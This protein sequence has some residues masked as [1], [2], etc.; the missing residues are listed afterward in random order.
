MDFIKT[1]RVLIFASFLMLF[2]LVAS[3]IASA[4]SEI[5]DPGYEQRVKEFEEAF[6]FINE[7]A[8]VKNKNGDVIDFDFDR[9]RELLGE[10]E[11]IDIA[12]AEIKKEREMG[13]DV[14]IASF[15][16]CMK[17]SL[18]DYFG[19]NAFNAMVNAGIYS[20]IKKKAWKD[21]AKIA[22][23]FFVGAS[24]GGLAITLA[25]YGGKCALFGSLE[26]QPNEREKAFI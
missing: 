15:W 13:G 6:R 10:S 8:T 7:E 3:P 16:G 11:A 24:A 1:R 12:E 17:D 26:A 2:T 5:S 4:E 14:Q 20:Y 25:Y 18:L 23:R 21:A 19:F 22:A 9:I